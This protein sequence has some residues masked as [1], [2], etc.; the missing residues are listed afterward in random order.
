[1]P[2]RR[3]ANYKYCSSI[4]TRMIEW[5]C[6]GAGLVTPG[7][8]TILRG[9]GGLNLAS[10]LEAKFGARS[11]QVHQIRGKTWELLLP[12]DTK[13]VRESQFWDHI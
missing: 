9:E 13:V 2:S 6:F 7:G 8:T 11:S 3:S 12:Q 1:M 5:L 10:S 4:P